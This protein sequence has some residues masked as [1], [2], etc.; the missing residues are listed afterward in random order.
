[1]SLGNVI[2]KLCTKNGYAPTL[3]LAG[4]R[5]QKLS[6]GEEYDDDDDDDQETLPGGKKG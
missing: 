3:R 1:M 6:S 4:I 5:N 2:K